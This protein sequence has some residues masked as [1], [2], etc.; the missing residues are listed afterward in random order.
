MTQ[1]ASKH[2]IAAEPRLVAENGGHR[3]KHPSGADMQIKI[4]SDEANGA[5]SLMQTILPPGGVIP[6]HIHEGEDENNYIVEGEL[7]MTIGT[8]AFHAKAGSF[9]VAPKGVTQTFTNP[10]PDACRFLTTFVPGGA[11][12]FFKEAAE[13]MAASMTNA[14]DPDALEMLQSKY[15]LTYL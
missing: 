10:G 9:V 11:E 12:G 2:V 7:L 15:R 4:F 1:L 13:L 5:Y 8:E 6:L 3:I 14:L